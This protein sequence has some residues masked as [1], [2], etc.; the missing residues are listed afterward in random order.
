MSLGFVAVMSQV[1][2]AHEGL[3]QQEA[4]TLVKKILQALRYWQRYVQQSWGKILVWTLTSKS[5]LIAIWE[6]TLIPQ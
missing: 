3:T 4:D 5:L 2:L 6:N 1:A